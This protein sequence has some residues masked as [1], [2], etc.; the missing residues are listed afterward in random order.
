MLRFELRES[1]FVL[2]FS[3]H[4]CHHSVMNLC[5]GKAEVVFVVTAKGLDQQRCRPHQ[6]SIHTESLLSLFLD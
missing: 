1:L 3:K 5:Y 6:L 2:L 4:K